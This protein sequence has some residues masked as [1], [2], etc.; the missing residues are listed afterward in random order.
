MATSAI[1]ACDRVFRPYL[2]SA[3]ER[4]MIPDQPVNGA[5]YAQPV[6]ALAP[7]SPAN[8]AKPGSEPHVIR[9]FNPNRCCPPA[10]NR[11]VSLED[12]QAEL[13][14]SIERDTQ[15]QAGIVVAHPE[16]AAAQ[17]VL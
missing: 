7:G 11:H 5:P 16:V 17:L 15:L 13:L 12:V 10:D 2:F 1:G 6:N 9:D 4:I 8:A 14:P 3:L